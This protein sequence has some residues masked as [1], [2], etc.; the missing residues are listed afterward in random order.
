M[1]KQLFG[2]AASEAP[3]TSLPP[4]QPTAQAPSK[5]RFGKKLYITIAAIAAIAVILVASVLLIPQGTADVISLGVQY[6]AGEK[7][8][9]DVTNSMSTQTGNSSSNVSSQ[10][11]LTVDVV[12][13]DGQTYTL[14]YTSVTSEGGYSMT[15]SQVIAVKSSE[16]V[17]VLALLPVGLQLTD[18]ALNSTST[19]PVMSAAFDQSQAKVGDT[20]QVPLNTEASSSVPP[21]NLTVTFKDIQSLTVPAGTYKVFRIDFSATQNSTPLSDESLN[22]SGQSYLEYGTC[23]QIQSNLQVTIPFNVGTASENIVD[24]FTSTLKQDQ[25]A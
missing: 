5:K 10:S 18:L 15:S 21:T 25:N 20:W 8:T 11:T 7:L 14:N 12:S 3:P 1:I 13:F 9:Y 4:E 19:S 6:S 24:T 22:L 16:M 23:K 17:T 2:S